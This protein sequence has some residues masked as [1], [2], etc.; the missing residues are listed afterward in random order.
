MNSFRIRRWE[1]RYEL[2]EI[3]TQAISLFDQY[4]MSTNLLNVVDA[5]TSVYVI[6]HEVKKGEQESDNEKSTTDIPTP[7]DSRD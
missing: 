2:N 1:E 5:N 4:S 6:D 3:G 7:P